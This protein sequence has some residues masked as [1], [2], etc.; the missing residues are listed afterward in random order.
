M[1]I[2]WKNFKCFVFILLLFHFKANNGFYASG[3]LFLNRRVLTDL[4]RV[5]E[6]FKKVEVP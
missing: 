5:V 1:E 6:L 4:E 2:D 3:A